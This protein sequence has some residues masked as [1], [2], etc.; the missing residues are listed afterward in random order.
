M[1]ALPILEKNSFAHRSTH[2]GTMH[3]CGH[4]GHTTMLLGAARYLANS[5][6]FAGRLTSSSSQP[7]KVSFVASPTI[8]PIFIPFLLSFDLFRLATG[9][10]QNPDCPS[11]DHTTF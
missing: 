1:D 6:N 3:A 9:S 4:D 2:D 8:Y 10:H 7:K 11:G 5:R